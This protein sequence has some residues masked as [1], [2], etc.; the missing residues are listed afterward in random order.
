VF[1]CNIPGETRPSSEECEPL[2]KISKTWFD[3]F[4][5]GFTY[6]LRQQDAAEDCRRVASLPDPPF[7][8][9]K[10]GYGFMDHGLYAAQLAWWLQFF[11]PEHFLIVP[12][13][14]LWDEAERL[15]VRRV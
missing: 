8:C 12:S 2:Q 13:A 14:E 6:M 4:K 9:S 7:D 1:F 15:E 3:C 10:P 5:C 11:P